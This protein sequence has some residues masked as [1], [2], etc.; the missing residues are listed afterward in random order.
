MDTYLED[1][2][3]RQVAIVKRQGEEQDSDPQDWVVSSVR[4]DPVNKG[5]A[6]QHA[7]SD[8]VSTG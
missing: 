4:F 2:G 5:I 3:W 6:D 8:N 7:N 1:A